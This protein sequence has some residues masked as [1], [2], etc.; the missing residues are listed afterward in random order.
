MKK[1]TVFLIALTVSLS[2]FSTYGQGAPKPIFGAKG[3]LNFANI[4]GETDNKLKTA[5]HAGVYSE[6][7]FDYFLMAQAE[8]LVSY[9]GHAPFNSDPFSSAL[10]LWYINLP[11]MARYNLGYNFNVHAGIQLGF[12]LSAK[13]K[14]N[15]SGVDPIDVKDQT[16]GFD[17]GIPVGVG[18][19]FWDRKMGVTA[20]YVIPISNISED[21]AFTRRNS[22]I[23]VSLGI[24]LMTIDE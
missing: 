2:S 10:N 12:L 23:Q 8:L 20:R 9:Q 4:T 6:V 18:Y 7:F 11:I 13:V 22:V 14:F 16:K 1:I 15:E 19:E 5:F 24:K 21:A 17:F 3:G